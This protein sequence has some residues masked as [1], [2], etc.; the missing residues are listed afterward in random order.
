MNNT[1]DSRAQ[2]RLWSICV[3]I[4]KCSDL[5]PV[6]HI[7]FVFIHIQT[8]QFCPAGCKQYILIIK[9]LWKISVGI[10]QFSW[11]MLV[12]SG[13]ELLEV[14]WKYLAVD[15]KNDDRLYHYVMVDEKSEPVSEVYLS[16]FLTK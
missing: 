12:I 9:L 1:P 7:E 15:W 4:V 5:L 14:K 16:S 11:Y 2:L 8:A 13:E 10:I 3:L 6:Y